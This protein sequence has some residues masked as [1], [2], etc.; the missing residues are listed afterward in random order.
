MSVYGL[1]QYTY[2]ESDRFLAAARSLLVWYHYGD[3]QKLTRRFFTLSGSG[4]GPGFLCRSRI[5]LPVTVVIIVIYISSSNKPKRYSSFPSTCIS[6]VNVMN[7]IHDR[8]WHPF[9]GHA[10]SPVI[11]SQFVPGV[12]RNMDRGLL[13]IWCLNSLTRYMIVGFN[14]QLENYI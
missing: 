1:R 8:Q 7:I 5:R 11:L 9:L 4:F 3:K 6:C 13:K 12:W 10:A 2:P 14:Y